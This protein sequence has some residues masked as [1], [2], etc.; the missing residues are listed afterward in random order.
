MLSAF[1]LSSPGCCVEINRQPT[2]HSHWYKKPSDLVSDLV[3]VW[4]F[5][6]SHGLASQQHTQYC[7]LQT[8]QCGT[9]LHKSEELSY[10][11]GCAI[12][13][14][15][16]APGGEKVDKEKKQ[17][18]NNWSCQLPWG[19]GERSVEKRVTTTF[20]EKWQKRHSWLAFEEGKQQNAFGKTTKFQLW[21]ILK[22]YCAA[23]VETRKQQWGIFHTAGFGL[24]S[25]WSFFYFLWFVL[26]LDITPK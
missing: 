21:K 20:N 7:T 11:V 22:H 5:S 25:S 15:R 26:E 12:F 23:P 2:T 17:T 8:A 19:G 4:T 9:G 3:P 10:T 24:T 14:M 18:N 6:W 16:R 1:Q 13:L